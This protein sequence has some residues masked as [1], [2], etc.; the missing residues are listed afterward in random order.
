MVG[1]RATESPSGPGAIVR[2][3]D[4]LGSGFSQTWFRVRAELTLAREPTEA[5]RLDRLEVLGAKGAAQAVGYRDEEAAG[6]RSASVSASRSGW[7]P[8]SRCTL[9]STS[10][11]KSYLAHVAAHVPTDLR[12]LPGLP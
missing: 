5:L 8:P 6:G 12:V 2:C 7:I 1:L 9:R 10:A 3:T 11:K 4:V